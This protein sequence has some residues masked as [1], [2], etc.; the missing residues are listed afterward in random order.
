MNCKMSLWASI[1]G[2][3]KLTVRHY[4]HEHDNNLIRPL[5]IGH[6]GFTYKQSMLCNYTHVD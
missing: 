1:S 6:Q 2:L 4:G 5:E 3:A